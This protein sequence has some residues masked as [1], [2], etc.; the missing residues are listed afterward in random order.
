MFD[1][2][3]AKTKKRKLADPAQPKPSQASKKAA[4]GSSSSTKPTSMKREPNAVASSSKSAASSSLSGGGGA[5][6]GSSKDAAKADSSFFSAPKQKAKLPSFKK[7]PPSSGTSIKKDEI[8]MMGPGMAMPSS[9]DPFQDVLKSMN[10]RKDSPAVS[11]P[12]SASGSGS[13]ANAG[14]GGSGGGQPGQGKTGKRKKTVTWANDDQLESVKI[15]ERAVYDDDP[16]DVSIF[17]PS[18]LFRACCVQYINVGFVF[19]ENFAFV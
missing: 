12:P 16:V 14:E 6:A 11:T 8:G 5:G 4:L 17:S 7:A 2:T 13:G 15:I 1:N 3:D 9:F 10:R 19:L 18:S